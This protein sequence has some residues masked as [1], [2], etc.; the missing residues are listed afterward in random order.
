MRL[1][2]AE[3]HALILHDAVENQA[4]TNTI[5]QFSIVRGEPGNPVKRNNLCS[6]PFGDRSAEPMRFAS[7][8]AARKFRT[9]SIQR[10]VAVSSLPLIVA[11]KHGCVGND[12]RF[13]QA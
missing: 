8:N 5:V 11:R 3:G 13:G 10:V 2:I 12:Q 4:L 1:T 7:N 6:D 9:R